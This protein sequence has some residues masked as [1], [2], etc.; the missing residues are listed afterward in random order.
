MEKNLFLHVEVLC[1]SSIRLSGDR[2]VY[3]DPFRVE[4]SPHNGDLILI[5]HEHFD[6]FSLEDIEKVQ[7]ADS[8]FVLPAS[9]KAHSIPQT[10][11]VGISA[12]VSHILQPN[13]ILS[14]V[15]HII[16]VGLLPPSILQFSIGLSL[17][18]V[19]IPTIIPIRRFR[20]S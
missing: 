6:H 2:V 16:L 1:H 10:T 20:N 8:F 7:K 5:T 4:G 12:A 14:L 3:I 17:R 15:S 9:S 18:T 11:I 19:P 13:G